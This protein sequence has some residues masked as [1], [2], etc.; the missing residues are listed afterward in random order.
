[1]KS[2]RVRVLSTALALSFLPVRLMAGGTLG[3]TVGP[4]YLQRAGTSGWELVEAPA[5]IGDG[6]TLKTGPDGAAEL[7][8]ADGTTARITG[9]AQFHLQAAAPRR[10]SF[11]MKLGL[12]EAFVKHMPGRQ[13]QV[14][15]PTSVAAIRGTDFRVEVAPSGQTSW[16]LFTGTLG[17]FDARGSQV[18]LRANH[19]VSIDNRGQAGSPRTLPPDVKPLVQPQIK[20]GEETKGPVRTAAG[21]AKT[22]LRVAALTGEIE[23]EVNGRKTVYKGDSLPSDLELPAGA[24]V[25]VLSGTAV[26]VGPQ[27]SVQAGPGA[28]LDYN[29][30]VAEG[31]VEASIT[32]HSGSSKFQLE[33]GGRIAVMSSGDKASVVSTPTNAEMMSAAGRIPIVDP[34]GAAQTLLPGQAPPPV[35]QPGVGPTEGQMPPAPPPPPPPPPNTVNQDQTVVSP[36]AP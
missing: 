14:R 1:M 5:E 20:A 27:V 18:V 34:N 21:P 11:F 12:L 24:R 16:S 33:V 29:A 9:N 23:V 13:F 6:D 2:S 15:T 19:S 3:R 35:G 17:I 10:M 8:F 36:S 32:A 31:R 22:T 4:V 28:D 7:A 25:K 30:V 26:L